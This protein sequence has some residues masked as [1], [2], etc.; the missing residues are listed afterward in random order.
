MAP[1]NRAATP[2]GHLGIGIERKDV[3]NLAQRADV[4]RLHGEGIVLA[5]EK[6]IQVEEL[7]AF[8]VPSPSTR[9]G[10]H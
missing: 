4:A 6:L 8:C 10:A 7:A 2:R 5:D 1:I 9:P 3:T